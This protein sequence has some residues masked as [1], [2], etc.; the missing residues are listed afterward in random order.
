M[1]DI[2]K[3]GGWAALYMAAVYAA[4]IV[5]FLVV[6]D[7]LDIVDPAEK[8]DLL[9]ARRGLIELTNLA[10]YVMFAAALTVFVLAL[11]DRV[12]TAGALARMG[13][14]TGLVWAGLVMASGLVANAGLE[15]AV[16]LAAT[17]REAAIAYWASVETVA[18]ALGG[19]AGEF[20]GGLTTLL[21]GL[22]SV[23]AGFARGAGWLGVAVGLIGI[24]ST[25]PVLYDL[26]GLFGVGQIAWFAWTG[27]AL[28]RSL[29]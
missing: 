24:V 27:V 2:R 12:E 7:Y 13:S 26:G 29:R 4:M 17:D 21:L 9:V 18:D 16:A 5:L 10:A 22:A 6:L 1:A 8:L 25:L 19:G 23:R 14:A 20:A 15:R 28:I 11:R 3:I